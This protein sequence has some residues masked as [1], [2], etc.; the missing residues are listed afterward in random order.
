MRHRTGLARQGRRSV[1]KRQQ[2][3]EYG[4]ADRH[5]GAYEEDHL[6]PLSIGGAPYDPRNSVA[7][8]SRDD[9]RLECRSEGRAR[10]GLVPTGLFRPVA[11]GGSAAGHRDGLGRSL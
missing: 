10:S 1:L 7:G 2:I 5:L 4:Y 3:R 6:I 11:A 9:G 8:A